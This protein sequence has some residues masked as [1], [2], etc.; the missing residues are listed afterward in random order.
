MTLITY[1]ELN[2]SGKKQSNAVSE[3]GLDGEPIKLKA[4]GKIHA[5][6]I[7]NLNE[8]VDNT[9]TAIV[10][11]AFSGLTALTFYDD[12]GTLKVKPCVADGSTTNTKCY[13]M[14]L[15]G[16]YSIGN[17]IEVGVTPLLEHDGG[18][19]TITGDWLFL[20]G[21]TGSLS[22]TEPVTSGHARQRIGM[23]LLADTFLFAPQDHTEVI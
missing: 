2:S 18:A 23:W 12:V 21:A 5:D 17:T 8:L 3:T 1:I 11:V 14:S 10:G 16:A 7:P 4:N 9:I 20:S 19:N 13:G 22:S 15:T 6:N